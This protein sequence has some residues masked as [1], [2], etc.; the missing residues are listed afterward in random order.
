VRVEAVDVLDAPDSGRPLASFLGTA[1][2]AAV[3]RMADPDRQRYTLR[4]KTAGGRRTVRIP[5]AAP[6][7][8]PP[9]PAITPVADELR[10]G[11]G[12]EILPDQDAKDDAYGAAAL[13]ALKVV[14]YPEQGRLAS[15][16]PNTIF[17][18]ARGCP[19]RTVKLGTAAGDGVLTSD[20]FGMSSFVF[21]RPQGIAAT[22]RTLFAKGGDEVAI[23]VSTL[24]SSRPV[25]MDVYRDCAWID[26]RALVP[27]GGEAQ[28][29]YALPPEQGLYTF[30]FY[31]NVHAPGVERARVRVVVPAG[32]PSAA[33]RDLLATV[34]DAGREP[35]AAH[36][37]VLVAGKNE[38]PAD[39]LRPAAAAFLSR[40]DQRCG[41]PQ[42]MLDSYDDDVLFLAASKQ[43]VK[44]AA[45]TGVG[46][47]WLVALL[48][49]ILIMVLRIRA[50]RDAEEP[51]EGHQR[52]IALQHA[53]AAALITVVFALLIYTLDVWWK[54]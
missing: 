31:G 54:Q 8:E 43:G 30:E 32:T 5:P 22:S 23:A 2:G 25:T 39:A 49:A 7:R 20:A 19:A 46:V 34:K 50:A 13:E 51:I 15:N 9:P 17:V 16:L 38:P 21:N 12:Q 35:I 28:V 4:V 42:L 24:A 26:S 3:V 53:L 33:V 37:G 6:V 36:L 10:T 1:D 47:T 18:W 27:A 14:M 44:K 40:L 52:H 29:A 11:G 48:G 41:P 45:Y